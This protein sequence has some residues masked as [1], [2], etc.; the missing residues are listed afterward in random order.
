[1]LHV[2][3]GH[4]RRLGHYLIFKIL[5]RVGVSRCQATMRRAALPR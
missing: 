2:I 5:Q 1:L 4:E 3:H